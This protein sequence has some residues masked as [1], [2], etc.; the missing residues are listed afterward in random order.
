MV[1]EE[2]HLRLQSL[3]AGLRLQEAW[4][5]VD[6]LD[7]E[8]GQQLP[9]AFHHEF[10]FLTSCPTNVGTGVRASVLMHLP[11]LVLTKEIGK[12]LQGLTQV[13]LTFR[14][15]YGEGSEV[16]GNFFQVSNQTTLGKSE[17]DLVD[18]LDKMVRRVIQFESHARQVLLRDA[19]AVTEDKICR[20]YGLLRYART[21]SFEELMNLLSGVRLGTSLK[22]L[23]GVR[24]YTLN[25]LMIFTQSAH[26]EQAA[27]RDLPP[28]EGDAHR[29]A[30]VRRLLAVEG[31]VDP[32]KFS[33]G[34]AGEVA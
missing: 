31:D 1:N 20:A 13:G 12:V 34:A 18:H 26:L 33:S 17:E 2:D 25:K 11:G 3:L 9:Y 19:R 10:G 24:V 15:L 22:L 29:A 23:P 7:E 4:N 27:G 32:E 30:Y 21:L 6:R 16:V 8:L 5:M 28:H 14:G